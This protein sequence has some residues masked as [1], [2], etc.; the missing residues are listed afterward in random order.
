MIKQAKKTSSALLT[1]VIIHIVLI[2]IVGLYFV[3]QTEIFKQMLIPES[4]EVKK[5]PKPNVRKDVV[6]PTSKPNLHIQN[7]A[8]LNPC[9]CIPG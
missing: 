1:V 6:K 2:I 8:I 7:T 4:S 3:T 9:K 5:P